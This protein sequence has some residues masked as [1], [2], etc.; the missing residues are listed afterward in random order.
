ME[1]K[2]AQEEETQLKQSNGILGQGPEKRS[3]DEGMN[4]QNR[5]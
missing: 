5:N 3:K 4:G 1:T 2:T